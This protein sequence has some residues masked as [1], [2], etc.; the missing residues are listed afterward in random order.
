[1]A[2]TV[3]T[4]TSAAAAAEQETVKS[5]EQ[6]LAGLSSI[7]QGFSDG[8]AEFTKAMS[9]ENSQF[10]QNMSNV[11]FGSMLDSMQKRDNQKRIDDEA[12]AQ[13]EE[14][15]KMTMGSRGPERGQAGF[16][17]AAFAVTPEKQEEVQAKA[18]GKALTSEEVKKQLQESFSSAT[19]KNAVKEGDARTTG[20][21]ALDFMGLGFIN[22]V[23]HHFQDRDVIKEDK[24]NKKDKDSIARDMK[25][26]ARLEAKLR[27]TMGKEGTEDEVSKLIEKLRGIGDS[28]KA[29][30]ARID[31]RKKP[32]DPYADL[33]EKEDN[34]VDAVKSPL[35][36]E[37]TGK[38]PVEKTLAPEETKKPVPPYIK[39]EDLEDY[40]SKLSGVVSTMGGPKLPTK[41]GISGEDKDSAGLTMDKSEGMVSREYAEQDEQVAKSMK[42]PAATGSEPGDGKSSTGIDLKEAADVGRKLDTQLRPEFYQEGTKAFKYLNNGKLVEGLSSTMGGALGGLAKGGLYAGLGAAAVAS[43]GAIAFAG[44]KFKDLLDAKADAKD[45]MQ[46]MTDANNEGLENKKKGWNDDAMSA[47]QE[48]NDAVNEMGQE[49]ADLTSDLS[50]SFE[51]SWLGRKLGW[52]SDKTKAKR[53]YELAKSKQK[54]ELAK[55]KSIKRAAEAAGIDVDD[56]EAM[57]KFKAEYDRTGGKIATAGNTSQTSE[58][59]AGTPG[60]AVNT[61]KVETAEQKAARDEE[62]MYRAVKRAQLDEEVQQKNIDAAKVTGQQIDESLVGRK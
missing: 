32:I 5:I 16:W 45:N 41:F 17:E 27:K 4:Q 21:R 29:A 47:T 35:L 22:K 11:M 2:D 36:P 12:K 18:I 61:D 9:D 56:A 33:V 55:V 23:K 57:N 39:A 26:K 53:K 28:I 51:E 7:M 31:E 10:F 37:L 48:A 20:E 13:N 60:A 6:K 59:N 3:Q 44:K 50:A 42:K 14:T 46:Q 19:I 30:E 38:K 24:A 25:E 58:P 40:Y 62:A 54:A 8:M 1:M 15:R 52:T 34:L 49:S 43:L